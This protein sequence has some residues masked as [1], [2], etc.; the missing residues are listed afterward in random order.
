MYL[1]Q[2]IAI[3]V[4]VFVIGCAVVNFKRTVL[5]WIP[6]SMLFNPQVCVI[7]GEQGLALTVAL[8]ISLV[9]FYFLFCFR[10][11]EQLELNSKSFYYNHVIWLNLISFIISLLVSDIPYFIGLKALIKTFLDKFCMIILAFRVLNTKEDILL[12]T[13]CALVVCFLIT[14][15]GLIENFTHINPAG[16]F[17]FYNSPFDEKGG[18]THYVPYLLN[19]SFKSRFGLTRCYSFFQIHLQFGFACLLYI[20]LLGNFIK[21]RWLIFLKKKNN[22]II[23][24]CVVLLVSGIIFCN[25]KGPLFAFCIMLFAFYRPRQIF[26]IKVTL[27]LLILVFLIV[28]YMPDYLNNFLAMTD[29][30]IAEEGGG[31]TVEMRQEQLS[32]CLKI[33]EMN[34]LF[35]MGVGAAQYYS[36]N[37]AG[38]EGILGAESCWFSLL[39]NVGLFGS[40]IYL[41]SYICLYKNNRKYMPY[42]VLSIFLIMIFALDSGTSVPS[43]RSLWWFSIFFAVSRNYELYDKN[44]R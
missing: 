9:I 32:L 36:K 4:F 13:K 11:Q 29:E 8:D 34:P 18:R 19:G 21:N 6:L 43:G 25:S 24:L 31:S 44:I 23:Y 37:I 10:K 40:A 30:D 41:Y 2:I 7:Y 26:N 22:F 3:F 38:F 42:K 35:G 33:F 15:N 1:V 39:P 14:V 20:F 5:L 27:P 28:T 17:I 16:D 12:F